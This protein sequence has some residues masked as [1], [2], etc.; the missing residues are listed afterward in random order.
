MENNIWKTPYT[1][2]LERNIRVLNLEDWPAERGV[3]PDG[4]YFKTPISDKIFDEKLGKVKYKE[5]STPRKTDKYL[6]WTMNGIVPY[7]LS[8]IQ[9]GIQYQHAVTCYG[10]MVKVLPDAKYLE[11]Y[12]KWATQDKT[13]MI[14]NGK[15]TNDDIMS[16]HYGFMQKF[17]DQLKEN[18][19]ML[20]EFREPDFND[21]LMAV[22]W[23]AD[24]RVWNRDVY[25]DYEA[26][27]RPRPP[28]DM[29]AGTS[30]SE[31]YGNLVERW[32]EMEVRNHAKWVEKIGGEKN[33]FLRNIMHPTK[34]QLAKN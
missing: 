13:T 11:H 1:W 34:L 29:W 16:P 17:R 33:A 5:N 30:T 23:M 9:A 10:E 22:V 18:K 12:E 8:G 28:K 4:E 31:D 3:T 19:V 14:F 21:S 15:T 24:E 32:K 25:P 6:I 26:T 2:C 20:N 7:Q 27:P